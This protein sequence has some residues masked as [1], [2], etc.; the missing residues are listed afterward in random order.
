VPLRQG[1]NPVLLKV[2]DAGGRLWEFVFEAFDEKG[3]PM[4]TSVD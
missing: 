1:Q 4:K 3:N 2:E